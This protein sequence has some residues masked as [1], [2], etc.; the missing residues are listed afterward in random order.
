MAK[1]AKKV[2]KKVT[3]K[4][5]KKKMGA[6]EAVYRPEYADAIEDHL[7][8]MYSMDAAVDGIPYG[9][10]VIYKFK[11]RYPE[12]ED[13]IKRGRERGM[14]KYQEEILKCMKGD[15][16]K[17]NMTAA[18][19]YGKNVFKWSDRVEQTVHTPDLKVEVQKE[20]DEL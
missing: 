12:F 15:N 17:A 3:K 14:Q 13:A 10:N 1:V 18:I 6:P 5:V 4:K 11:E 7:A 8:N 2:T 19:W 9:K 16:P 20:D